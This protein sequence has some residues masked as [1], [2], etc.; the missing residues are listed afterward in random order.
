M[1]KK[2][3]SPVIGIFTTYCMVNRM[4][5]LHLEIDQVKPE[6]PVENILFNLLHHNNFIIKN[7]KYNTYL[8]LIYFN[9]E[10]C[11]YNEKIVDCK[12]EI[13]LNLSKVEG[14]NECI[15]CYN[16]TLLRTPTCNHSLCIS[17]YTKLTDDKC[18]VCRRCFCCD[19]ED[20]D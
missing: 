13:L 19:D 5:L 8:N 6:I 4:Q 16:N 2:G 15:V 14:D 9:D 18:P 3:L 10:D 20:S 1:Y 11:K 12:N 17:C 7:G